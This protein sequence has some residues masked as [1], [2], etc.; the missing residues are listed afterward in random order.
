MEVI[1]CWSLTASI[2]KVEGLGVG[3]GL[4]AKQ[5]APMQVK[6]GSFDNMGEIA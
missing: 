6:G 4:D 2:P 3:K 5:V 1:S